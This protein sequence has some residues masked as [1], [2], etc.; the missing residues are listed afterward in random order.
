MPGIRFGTRT[1]LALLAVL[2]TAAPAVA[3]LTLFE[4]PGITLGDDAVECT[5]EGTYRHCLADVGSERVLSHDGLPV[6]DRI[7][8]SFQLFLPPEPVSGPDGNHPLVMFI[9][10]WSNSKEAPGGGLESEFIPYAEGGY[11]VLAWDARAWGESCGSSQVADPDCQDQWNHLAD[12]RYEVRDAQYLAGL[13]VDELSDT[14]T[15]IVDATRIGATGVSYGGAQSTMLTT[16][17]DRVVNLNGTTSPWTS[18]AGTPLSLAA[19]APAWAW[20]DL[21]YGLLPNGRTLDYVV[22]DDYRGPSGTDPFG[23]SKTSY[24]SGLFAL[25]ASLSVYAPP[26]ESPDLVAWKAAIDAGEPYQ[27][28]TLGSIETEIHDF[29]AG[30]YWLDVA[31][32]PAP[33][34]FNSGWSDDIFPVSEPV[35][36]IHRAKH[37]HGH[38]FPAK[39]V[40]SNYGH[41]RALGSGAANGDYLYAKATIREWFDYWLMGIGAEPGPTI[42]ARTQFCP[43]GSPAV[44]YGGESWHGIS[45]GEVVYTTG[46]PQVLTSSGGPSSASADTF[47]PIAGGDACARVADE[48]VTGTNVYDLPAPPTGGYTLLGSPTLILDGN[49]VGPTNPEYT[50]IAVRLLD[51][52]ASGDEQLLARG[53]YRPD[54]PTGPFVFQLHPMGHHI[55][56]GHHLQLELLGNESPTMRQS[57]VS[58]AIDITDVELR[59]PVAESP[60]GGQIQAPAAFV[61]PSGYLPEP[62][63]ALS[64]TAGVFAL[65]GLG[66]IRRGRVRPG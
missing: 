22:D 16:L 6:G 18:P 56:D 40:A 45:P 66:R 13:L 53:V 31:V 12:I 34:L 32:E 46:S 63:G 24:V 51:V 49:I 48:T 54:S 2:M 42:R 52:D 27:E 29:H 35:R 33:T 41:A 14:G 44:D 60:D 62:S 7:P 20:T 59:V 19:A 39:L 15:P 21:A 17:R 36:W 47:D 26:G 50:M 9:H 30:Y 11:A 37:L 10:G 64:L 25:G 8:I 65:L 57:N 58:F 23:V 55:A 4:T 61:V 1:T 43:G 38:D 3:Q 5:D 28:A